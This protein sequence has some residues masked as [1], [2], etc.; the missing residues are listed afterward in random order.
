LPLASAVA[1]VVGGNGDDVIRGVAN[2]DLATHA[3]DILFGDDGN[4]TIVG[5]NGDDRI[6]GGAGDDMLTGLG[7][8]DLFV[9]SAHESGA[10]TITDFVAGTDK[11]LLS[12]AAD[13]ATADSD[14]GAV[15]TFGSTTIL[16]AGVHAAD[17]DAADFLSA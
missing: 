11:I 15:I 4:D 9:F 8:A 5:G 17:L 16:L 14:Q 3:P 2:Q 1:W 13:H 10:D 12:G 6:A 7:G